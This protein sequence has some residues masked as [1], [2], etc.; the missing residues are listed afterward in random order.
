MNKL[1]NK[2]DNTQF[3]VGDRVRMGKLEG[4]VTKVWLG[5]LGNYPVEVRWDEDGFTEFTKDG[6]I[7]KDHK[8]PVLEVIRKEE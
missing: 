8:T 4:I 5:G 2:L 3:K 7:M 6:K 1:L